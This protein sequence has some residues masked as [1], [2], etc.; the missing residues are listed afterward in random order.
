MHPSL[1]QFLAFTKVARLGS[2]ARAAEALGTSQPALSQSI[3]Q[4]EELLGL[5]LFQRTTR[6]VRMTAEG[7]FLLPRAERIMAGVEE[8]MQALQEHAQQRRSRISIGTLPS[9][10]TGILPTALRLYRERYPASQ[11]A[12]M[13]G[14]S[15]VLYAGIEA[16]QLDV[17]IGSRLPGHPDVSFR[18]VLRERFALV[19]R[20]EHPLARQETVTWREALGQDFIAFP[21]GSG[22]RAAMQDALERA[23]LALHPVMTLAQSNTV[24][25]MVEAGVGVTALPALGCPPADH[26]VLTS[27]ALVEPVVDREVGILS[28]M[29]AS[30]SAGVL[31]FQEL[32]MAC[33]AQWA[34]PGILPATAPRGRRGQGG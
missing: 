30:P 33:I 13:D 25:G 20:R 12:V 5:K 29:G 19:L 34:A 14:T 18:P 3:A 4:M 11:L 8:A 15:D 1:R 26:K 31:A 16:G 7:E 2:F 17:A 23:G 21:P 28:A 22:G 32:I 9:F 6:A 24:M 10:A 27:R